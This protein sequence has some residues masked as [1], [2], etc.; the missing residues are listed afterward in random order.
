V[1]SL[2]ATGSADD[3][4]VVT[5]AFADSDVAS[6]ANAV[7]AF[8]RISVRARRD[9][10]DVLCRTLSDPRAAVRASAAAGLRYAGARC[11]KAPERD[12][13]A[14]DRSALVRAAAA[15]LLRDV[16]PVPEDRRAL[17]RCVA[18]EPDGAVATA[19][20]APPEVPKRGTRRALV[21]VVPAGRDPPVPRAAG[22]L[23][24]AGGHD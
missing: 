20:E 3:L 17:A 7:T 23:R 5:Q 21:Y 15:A 13:L 8:A 22:A 4:E 9:V 18:D 10:R 12:A 16:A 2:G 19:C 1:W 11:A 6:A 14:R 24:R